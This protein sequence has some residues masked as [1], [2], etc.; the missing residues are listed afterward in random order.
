MSARLKQGLK[1]FMVACDFDDL[2]SNKTYIQYLEFLD[3]QCIRSISDSVT[4]TDSRLFLVFKKY[5]L[6]LA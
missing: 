2:A 3:V 1:D 5:Q 6:P 4:L